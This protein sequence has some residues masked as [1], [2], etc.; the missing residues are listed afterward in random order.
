M[1]GIDRPIPAPR[2]R[3]RFFGRP[4]ALPMHHIS[5]AVKARVPVM[6]IAPILQPDGK[7]HV[8]TSDL[9]EMDPHPDR[10][11]EEIR[12]AEKVLAIAERFIRQAPHQW[13]ISLPVWPEA[14]DLVPQGENP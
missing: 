11:T 6:I 5:L 13:S 12:N 4:A 10:A 8:L 7:Y 14:L 1:T 3:P 2:V 9:I